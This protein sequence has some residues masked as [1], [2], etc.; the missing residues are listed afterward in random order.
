MP[1]TMITM[2]TPTISAATVSVVRT[3]DRW[4]LRLPR[5]PLAP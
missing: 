4:M 2:A 1:R 5:F 3:R